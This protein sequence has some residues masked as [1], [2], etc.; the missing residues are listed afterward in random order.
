MHDVGALRTFPRASVRGTHGCIDAHGLMSVHGGMG[1]PGCMGAQSGDAWAGLHV[2]APG[3]MDANEFCGGV[4]EPY[5]AW[6]RVGAWVRMQGVHG[7]DWAWV[8][9]G[10]R[11]HMRS[12]GGARAR[13]RMGAPVQI[14][15]CRE[16]LGLDLAWLHMGICSHMGSTEGCMSWF[17]QSTG[18]M[19]V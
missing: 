12:A 3:C 2:G 11:P 10:T 5:C 8:H 7:L 13:L 9:V 1:E 15:L 16:A 6:V 14:G 19:G 17:T 18:G 4:H